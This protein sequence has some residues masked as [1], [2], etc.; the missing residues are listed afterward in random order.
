MTHLGL[1][2]VSL[3]NAGFN[4]ALWPHGRLHERVLDPDHVMKSPGSVG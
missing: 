1:T 3:Y 2:T 4:P